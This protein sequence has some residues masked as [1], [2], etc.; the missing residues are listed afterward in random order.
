MVTLIVLYREFH[1]MRYVIWS[2][3]SV[4]YSRLRASRVG[5]YFYYKYI[6]VDHVGEYSMIYD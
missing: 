4:S 2:T 1:S 6:T 3:Q 5:V